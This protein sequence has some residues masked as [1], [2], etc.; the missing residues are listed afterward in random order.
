MSSDPVRA[1]QID[2]LLSFPV[3]TRDVGTAAPARSGPSG[4]PGSAALGQ[5][6]EGAL[7][8]ALGWRPKADDSK[9]FLAALNQSFTCTEVEGRSVC[10]WSPKG[11]TLSVQADL[12]AI[13]GA[14]KSLYARARNVLDQVLPLLAGLNAL[15]TD[16]DPEESSSM[17]AIIRSELVELTNELGILGGPRVPRVEEIFSLLLGPDTGASTDLNGQ[18]RTLRDRLGLVLSRV[19]TIEEE[20]DVSNFLLLVDY[21]QSLRQSWKAQKRFFTRT[22]DAFFGTQ[23]VLLSKE[24]AVTVESIQELYFAMDS[25]FLGPAER[26]TTLLHLEG[27][28][29]VLTLAELL[30]WA[31]RF[32]SEEGPRVIQAGGKDGI[33]AFLSTAYRLRA[34]I[35]ELATASPPQFPKHTNPRLLS[36]L[37]E[38]ADHFDALAGLGET[39]RKLKILHIESRVN[40]ATLELTLL[41]EN[42]SPGATVEI[43]LDNGP[44]LRP[45]LV[46]IQPETIEASLK[47]PPGTLPEGTAVVTNPDGDKG[48]IELPPLDSSTGPA[49]SIETGVAVPGWPVGIYNA[50]Y[51]DLGRIELQRLGHSPIT[52]S[53]EPWPSGS[54]WSGAGPAPSVL[55][56]FNLSQQDTGDWEAV[57]FDTG[58]REFHRETFTIVT[59]SSIANPN[60]PPAVFVRNIF[61]DSLAAGCPAT[62]VI[63]N[64]GGFEGVTHVSFG[65]GVTAA[66]PSILADGDQLDVQ[67]TSVTG[68][69]GKRD[70]TITK[71]A[72]S[73]VLKNAFEIK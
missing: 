45:G 39:G 10:K 16:A 31:E 30:S 14:Q 11:L 48:A 67:I 3:L 33:V 73:V 66:A 24:L 46:A 56:T 64:G 52:G 71:G 63:F 54:I 57:L 4:A 41:G 58:N 72:R 27:G 21:V 25:L 62:T 35:R 18:F 68:T 12:G 47:L 6:V 59:G 37:G 20:Q 23:L 1:K 15:R 69:A 7:R 9:G 22:G 29:T 61:P 53:F 50:K 60:S 38:T 17:T 43:V 19:N 42:F 5:L 70:I 26:E 28:A 65:P 51:S 8:E 36:P 2:D 55:V 40:G 32:V 34:L 44:V 13:S 49:L